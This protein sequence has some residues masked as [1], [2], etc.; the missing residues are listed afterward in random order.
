MF[1]R[2]GLAWA[3][4]EGQARLIPAGRTHEDAQSRGRLQ[5]KELDAPCTRQCVPAHGG[6]QP[7]RRLQ[8]G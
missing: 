7:M 4:G 2:E 3:E 1:R 6:D 8:F 5:S